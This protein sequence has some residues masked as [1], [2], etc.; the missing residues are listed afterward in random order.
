M[1]RSVGPLPNPSQREADVIDANW[2]DRIEKATRENGVHVRHGVYVSVLGPSYE[3][4]AEIRMYRVM[5]GDVIGM[6]TV[7]EAHHA[8]SRGLSVATLSLVTNVL[9]DINTPTVDHKHVVEAGRQ[10]AE[11]LWTV[12]KSAIFTA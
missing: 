6:S 10:G 11:A 3:T 1:Q 7:L 4:R 5:G 12:L 9:S 2:S 8:R